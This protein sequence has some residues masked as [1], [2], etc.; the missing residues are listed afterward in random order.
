MATSAA[1]SSS[2]A[3]YQRYQGVVSRPRVEPGLGGGLVA[4][5]Q[6]LSRASAPAARVR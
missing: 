5:R 1:V 3:V 2:R 6:E 4:E